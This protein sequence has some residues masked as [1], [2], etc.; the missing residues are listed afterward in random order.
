MPRR[1]TEPP[2]RARLRDSQEQ[3]KAKLE[4]RIAL[5]RELERKL[6]Y[7]FV[8]GGVETAEEEFDRWHEVNVAVL[9]AMFDTEDVARSYYVARSTFLV[10]VYDSEGT[11][12]RRVQDNFRSCINKLGT[13]I[14]TL[15]TYDQAPPTAPA[16]I[17]QAAPFRHVT[18]NMYGGAV[19]NL[20][21]GQ[22]IGTIETHVNAV[23]GPDADQ[24]R[25][26]VKELVEA[27]S[28]DARLS[29]KERTEVLEA[30]DMVSEEAAK[31]V[32]E[33]RGTVIRRALAAIPVVLNTATEAKTVWDTFGPVITGFFGH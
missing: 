31:L 26:A 2:R 4:E 17:V 32:A 13:I 12:L 3:A 6:S 16:P 1:S 18:I 14:E 9:S 19:G 15:P 28:R 33:R 8:R 5:G 21:L 25:A 24:L 29:N 22:L 10:S 7:P 30:L 27:T 11:R 20:N 23:S